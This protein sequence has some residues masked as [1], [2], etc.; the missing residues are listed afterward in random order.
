MQG[1]VQEF[2]I[3]PTSTEAAILIASPAVQE[4]TV[5]YNLCNE[6]WLK[7]TWHVVVDRGLKPSAWTSARLHDEVLLLE[8]GRCVSVGVISAAE[9]I[10]QVRFEHANQPGNWCRGLQSFGAVAG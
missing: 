10:L 8:T 7:Y 1:R 6:P 2:W 9:L 4:I 3:G 5:M